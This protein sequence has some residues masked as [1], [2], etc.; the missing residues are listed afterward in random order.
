MQAKQGPF[1]D[2]LKNKD[3]KNSELL[4]EVQAGY[5]YVR[6]YKNQFLLKLEEGARFEHVA[7]GYCLKKCFK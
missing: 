1:V 4:E 6:K 2:L 7:N 5:Q 3:D